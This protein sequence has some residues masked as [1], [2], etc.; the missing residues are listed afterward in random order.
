MASPVHSLTRKVTSNSSL[1][2]SR[3]SKKR[4][5]S[6]RPIL[7]RLLL[8]PNYYLVLR[9]GSGGCRLPARTPVRV[10]SFLK[11]RLH[12]MEKRFNAPSAHLHVHVSG[13]NNCRNEFY[14]QI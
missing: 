12:V 7:D 8:R 1:I 11:R 3:N 13:R 4:W 2:K 10:Q 9:L 6:K 14:G 5:P